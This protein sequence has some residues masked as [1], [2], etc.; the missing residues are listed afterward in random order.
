MVDIFHNFYRG[1]RVLVTGHTGFKGSWLSIWLHELGAEVIGLALEPTS[2]KDNYVLSGI[3]TM[4]TDLRGDIRNGELLKEIFKTY[5]PDIVFHLA[6]QPLVRLSYEMPV[7]TYETNV[8][9]TVNILE[10]IRVLQVP[11]KSVVIITTDKVYEN[12]GWAWGYRENDPL[13]GHDPYSNSKSCAEL[14]THSYVSS[15]FA[16]GPAI[17][18]A[19]AGNVIGGSGSRNRDIHI[20]QK[21]FFITVGHQ[22]RAGFAVGIWIVSVQRFVFPVAPGPFLVFIN[23]VRGYV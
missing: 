3:G 12:K 2:E 22:F 18:T 21:R 20:I 14:V 8:M 11:V 5:Q 7:E 19:R 17:S 16:Q 23:L 10:C 15:F 6:A 1:K 4:I 13:D 9:G